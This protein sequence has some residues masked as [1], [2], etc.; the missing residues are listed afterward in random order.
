[1]KKTI[2]FLLVSFFITTLAYSNTKQGNYRWRD[3]SV[4]ESTDG[5]WLADENTNTKIVVGTNIRLR[6][7]IYNDHTESG[8]NNALDIFYSESSNHTTGIWTKITASSDTFRLSTTSQYDE[9]SAPTD[10][11]TN[12]ASL[13]S[14]TG[15]LT[16]SSNGQWFELQN[17]T[18]LEAEFCITATTTAIGEKTYYFAI[19]SPNGSYIDG[20][21]TLPGLTVIG[22][23]ITSTLAVTSI[24]QTTAVGNGN[25]T[26][27]GVQ[28]PT[29]HGMCWNTTGSPTLSD[30]YTDEGSASVSGAFTS[31]MVS[32]SPNTTCYVRAY[33]TNI[34]GTSYGSEESFTTIKY[35]QIITFA[36]LQDKTTA[37]ADYNPGATSDLGIDITYESYDETVATIVNDLIHIVG[38]GKVIII[39][40]QAGNDTVNATTPVMKILTVT[41]ATGVK[42][43]GFTNLKMY[44]NPAKDIVTL[45]FG[46]L[47]FSDNIRIS[48]IDLTGK[49]VFSEILTD[50]NKSIPLS[51]YDSGLYFVEIR[52]AEDQKILQ[53]II[54]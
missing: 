9:G 7:E 1:M 47:P 27:L 28:N 21:A 34:H 53:L 15:Y 51:K 48:I 10:L 54:E 42:N 32:L 44:P 38:A 50:N 17:S 14:G 23:P 37:D 19:K 29:A 30:Y 12:T 33:A 25:I 16:E 11:L 6:I 13:T 3:D 41:E 8:I 26:N 31:D 4:G 52:T 49:T 2:T 18:S 5:G 43:L 20:Y 46:N 39:A 40:S 36:E 45:E 35:D 22:P 24:A